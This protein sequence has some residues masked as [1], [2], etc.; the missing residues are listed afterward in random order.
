MGRNTLCSYT[1]VARIVF[2]TG[3]HDVALS[4][5]NLTMDTRLASNTFL[6]LG[7]QDN[8]IKAAPVVVISMDLRYY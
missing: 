6:V 8:V 4:G 7:L 1:I 3:F 5:L 2:E